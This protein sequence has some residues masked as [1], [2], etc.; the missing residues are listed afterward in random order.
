[1]KVEGGYALLIKNLSQANAVALATGK[2]NSPQR[3]AHTV[4]QDVTTISDHIVRPIFSSFSQNRSGH[5]CQ[6]LDITAEFGLYHSAR[7]G[8]RS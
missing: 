3:Q 6:T 4:K 1:M 8:H 5:F 7:G 2:A